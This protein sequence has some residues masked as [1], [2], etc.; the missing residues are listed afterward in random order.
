AAPKSGQKVIR[1]ELERAAAEA[2]TGLAGAGLL[3]VNPPWR[4]ADEL[5]RIVPALRAAL[6]LPAGGRGKVDWLAGKA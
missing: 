2:G 3:V 5:G 4:L 6:G 1:V